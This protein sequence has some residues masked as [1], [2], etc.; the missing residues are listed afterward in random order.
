MIERILTDRIIRASS[1]SRATLVLG[2]RRVGKTTAMRSFV[3]KDQDYHFFDGDDPITRSELTNPS[4]TNLKSILR[5]HKTIFIDEA[6]RIENIGLTVKM[7]IDRIQDIKVFMS[8]S[9]AI[10]LNDTVNEPLTG[11][12]WQY[13]LLPLSYEEIE[14][15]IGYL[16]AKSQL[17]NRI[18]YGSY[19]EVVT[20]PGNERNI[21]TELASSYLYR[22][23]L[24]VDSLRK[25]EYLEKLVKMLAYQIGHEVSYNELANALKIDKKTV[26]SYIDLLEKSYVVFRL[27]SYSRNLRNELK[28]AK[29]IYFYDTGIR[30]TIINDFKPFEERP[31]RGA[32]WEN[33]LVAEKLKQ[34]H[35]HGLFSNLYFWRNTDQREIDLLEEVDGTLSAFEFKLN[36]KAKAKFPRT[37]L[38]AYPESSFAKIDMNNFREFL[39]ISQD[40]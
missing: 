1:T 31:D 40:K 34:I 22:D 29:K 15:S 35:N 23:I 2:P 33:Y 27:P 32:L 5:G 39:K 24:S 17:V 37:F 36:P 19:P 20:H 18:I 8:G 6:Q 16:N 26:A 25:P 14:Q 28:R 12:K 9:S 30:N 3:L 11:R 7:I 38:N 4:L 10:H 13:T 21:L